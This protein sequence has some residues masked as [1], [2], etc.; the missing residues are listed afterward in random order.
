[1]LSTQPVEYGQL[2]SDMC[3]H[4]WEVERL[5]DSSQTAPAHAPLSIQP[6][7]SSAEQARLSREY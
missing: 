5:T 3:M 6:C 1:M 4:S 2:D 7:I